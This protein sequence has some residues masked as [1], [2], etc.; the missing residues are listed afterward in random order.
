MLC[1][2]FGFGLMFLFSF[3][4]FRFLSFVY[5]CCLVVCPCDVWLKLLIPVVK[6]V[7]LFGLYFGL[8]FLCGVI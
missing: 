1:V 6:Y 7:N 3:V 4:C 5:V 2:Y 8:L